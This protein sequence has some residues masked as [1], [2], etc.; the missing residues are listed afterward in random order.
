VPFPFPSIKR[1]ILFSAA[2]QTSAKGAY[3]ELEMP[4]LL[5][6]LVF[7]GIVIA[8]AAFVARTGVKAVKE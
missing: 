6:A 3:G 1:I 4:D 2:L 8:P 7:I 5:V